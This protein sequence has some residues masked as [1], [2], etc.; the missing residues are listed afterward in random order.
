MADFRTDPIATRKKYIEAWNTTMIKIWKERISFL[1][2]F[3]SGKLLNS[4][5]VLKTEADGRLM[6]IHLSQSFLEYGLWQDFGTG[7][8]IPIGNPG[9]V[10]CLDPTYRAEHNLDEPR[11]RGPKWGGGETSGNPREPRPWY[12]IKYYSSVMNL[13]RFYAESLGDEFK[14]I[15]CDALDSAK[16]RQ[17]T[18]Y[19]KR[20][21]YR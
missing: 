15:V 11:K 9:D 10:K 20:K 19:Y 8:E 21:G 14:S 7:R 12:S 6:D 18:A 3:D 13:T 5:I 1:G 2:I 17:N 4:P 16:Y